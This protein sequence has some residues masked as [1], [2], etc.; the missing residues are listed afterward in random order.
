MVCKDLQLKVVSL[1]AMKMT[2][3]ATAILVTTAVPCVCR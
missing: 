1:C 2:E 3:K